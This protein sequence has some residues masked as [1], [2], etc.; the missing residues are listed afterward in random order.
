MATALMCD[1]SST[2]KFEK[3]AAWLGESVKSAITMGARVAHNFPCPWHGRL[4][5]LIMGR[6]FAMEAVHGTQKKNPTT[7]L[8]KYEYSSLK[9][10]IFKVILSQNF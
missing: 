4:L 5:E 10:S 3:Y 8:C 2:S 7:S 9:T 6:R 1:V